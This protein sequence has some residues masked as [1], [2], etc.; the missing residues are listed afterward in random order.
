[1]TKSFSVYLDALRFF[2]A[3]LVVMSHFAYPRFSGGSWIWIRE[4]N[5]GSDAVIVFF[6]MS[7]LVISYSA[8][9]KPCGPKQYV[10]DRLTRLFSVALPALLIGFALDCLGSFIAPLSYEGWYY[11]PLSLWEMLLRGLTFSNEWAGLETRMGSNGPYWSLSYEAAYYALFGFM[12]FTKGLLRVLLIV[13][14]VVAAGVNIFLL[15][16]CWL[17]GVVLQKRISNRRL[18]E[19]GGAIACAVIP[20]GLYVF[21]L[22]VGLPKLLL[23]VYP[24]ADWGLRFSDEFVWNILLSILVGVHL[25]GMGGLLS[26]QQMVFQKAMQ[27]LAGGSFSL[28]ILHYPA[29]QFFGAIGFSGVSF[30]HQVALLSSTCILCYLFAHLFERPLARWR[31]TVRPL[32]F[33]RRPATT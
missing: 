13:T 26:S 28:Y 14:G 29:L 30:S 32:F 12:I 21:A 3:F 4:L 6:V 2:A 7:G 19:A 18:P 23:Q 10:F 33:K 16:P 24:A 31:D 20:V 8:Q 11:N 15:M 5:L 17:V 27:W 22:M 9:G 25:L 1:M